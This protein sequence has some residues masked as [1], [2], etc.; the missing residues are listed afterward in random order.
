M[1]A[2]H[3]ENGYIRNFAIIASYEMSQFLMQR[4]HGNPEFTDEML[5]KLISTG[6]ELNEY[7]Y[8]R[9]GYDLVER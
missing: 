4:L 7:Q 1:T 8:L 6:A 9:V 2:W 3:R 5:S